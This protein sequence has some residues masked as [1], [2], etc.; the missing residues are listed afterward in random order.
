MKNL[1]ACFA[2]CLLLSASAE[3]LLAQPAPAPDAPTDESPEAPEATPPTA[4]QVASA[5]EHYARGKAAQDAGDFDVASEEY[6]EAYEAFPQPLLLYNVA[7]VKRLGG[8]SAEAIKYY[9]KYL[10]A[11]PDGPGAVNSREIVAELREAL[12]QD[13]PPE[14][15]KVP[16]EDE[17]DSLPI[18]PP[19]PEITIPLLDPD[20]T[21]GGKKNSQGKSSGKTLKIAGLSTAGFGLV[22][23]GAGAVF[24]LRAASKSDEVSSFEGVWSEEQNQ[25][26]DDGE[27]AESLMIVS[28]SIGAAALVTGG[29]LY[30]MGL[31]KETHSE[32][33]HVGVTG[34][35][36]SF[37]VHGAY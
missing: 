28:T 1:S 37:F 29:L 25:L 36:V 6:L 7:Q 31:R 32:Q 24:G 34:D 11:D 22:A 27:S 12:A 35:S 33:V 19:E 23:L 30:Y 17:P 2:V 21:V 3:P 5:R 26:F 10:A 14:Q 18:E 9:E 20:P 15:I 4:E 8:S 16:K 13:K